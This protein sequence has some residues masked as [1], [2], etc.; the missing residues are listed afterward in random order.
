MYALV[1][2][3]AFA[4]GVAAGV[5]T[6]AAAE[7]ATPPPPAPE[8]EL[9]MFESAACPYCRQWHEEIGGIYAKTPEGRAA[10]LRRVD[11]HAAPPPDLR[12]TFREIVYTPTFVLRA[13]GGAQAEEIGRI[14][15]YPGEHFFWPM[16]QNL[17]AEAGA[18][19]E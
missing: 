7:P 18:G 14:A 10:P 3:A 2:G 15:G 1:S 19:I 8:L 6:A 13:T 9:V 11:L 17:L 12:A 4:A 16:L 5:A